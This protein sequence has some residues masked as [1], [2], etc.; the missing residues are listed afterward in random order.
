MKRLLALPLLALLACT[1]ASSTPEARAAR[2][3]AS[4]GSAAREVG[5]AIEASSAR[6]PASGTNQAARSGLPRLTG[7]AAAVQARAEARETE[8]AWELARREWATLDLAKLDDVARRFVR[9]RRADCAWRSLASTNEADDSGLVAAKKELTELQNAVE[10]PELRDELWARVEE[11]LA[12][13]HWLPRNRQD[14]GQAWP[15]YSNALD[16]WA[17]AKDVEA[18]RARYLAMV[19]RMAW[20]QDQLARGSWWA[21]QVPID[22]LANAMSIAKTKDDQARAKYLFAASVRWNGG[23]YERTRQAF[24]ALE[25][26]LELGKG[27]PWYDDAL[28][29]LAQWAESPGIP[30]VGEDGNWRYVPDYPKALALYRRYVEEFQK[31]QAARWDDAKQ[32]IERITRVEV[33]VAVPSAFLPGSEAGFTLAWRNAAKVDVALYA[34]DLANAVDLASEQDTSASAWLERVSTAGRERVRSFTHE[35]KD[36]GKHVPGST[37]LDL[38]AALAPGAY[39]LE[40]TAGGARS[41]ELVLVGRTQIVLKAGDERALAWVCDALTSEPVANA[42][43]VVWEHVYDGKRWSWARTAGTSA[44]DGTFT[45]ALSPLRAN[46]NRSELLVFAALGERES[47]A[48][49]GTAWERGRDD[50]W[51][52]YAVTDRPV[53][54]P[55]NTVQWKLTARAERDGRMTTPAGSRLGYELFDPRGTSVKKGELVL[56]AFGSAWAELALDATMALGEYRAQFTVKEP[57]SERGIGGA[58]L[59]RLEEYKLPEFEVTLAT[60]IVDGKAKLYRLGERVECDLVARTYFGAPVG[61]ADVEVVVYQR[62]FWRRWTDAREYPWCYATDDSWRWGRWNKGSQVTS[63]TAKTD[64]EGKARIAFDTPEG[65]GQDLEYTLEARVTDASRREIRSEQSIRVTQR[66]YD[67]RTKLAHQLARPGDRVTVEFEARDAN[68]GPVQAE[69]RVRL[70]RRRFVEVWLDPKGAEVRGAALDLARASDL[71]VPL[72][73]RAGWRLKKSGYEEELVAETVL[74]TNAEGKASWAVVVPTEGSYVARWGSRDDRR[75][76]IQSE[77]AF[78]VASEATRDTGWR[79]G[80]VE[81]VIDQDTFHLGDDA[82]VMIATSTSN[83]W[84]LFTLEGERLHSFQVVH[85]EGTAKL[86]RV[87]IR[88]EHLPNLWLGA[89]TV[90]AGELASDV[91]EVVVPPTPK[92][93]TVEVTPDAAQHEPGAPGKLSVLVKDARGEPVA[94]ELTLSVVDESVL[95]IQSEYA[96][97]PRPFFH[98]ERRRHD[99]QSS[100]STDSRSFRRFVKDAKGRLR[101]E[102]ETWAEGSDEDDTLSDRS[103]MKEE[104]AK[105]DSGRLGVRAGGAKSQLRAAGAPAAKP[106]GPSTGGPGGPVGRGEA[107]SLGFV[108][109]EAADAYGSGGAEPGGDAGGGAVQV[110]SDFRETALWKPD[111][112][113]GADGRGE[114]TFTYPESLTRWKATARAVTADSKA[115]IATTTTRTAKP[116]TARLQTP[117]FLVVG[118]EAVLSALVDNQTDAAVDAKAE[119]ALG[120]LALVADAPKSLSVP[121]HG[122]VRFDWKVRATDAGSAKLS[123]VARAGALSDG[124]TRALP[125]L[126][127]GID[128]QVARSVRVAEGEVAFT[129]DVPAARR[130]QDTRFEVQ[131]A[132]SLA[133]TMLDALPYLVDYPYGCTEQTMSR[134]LPAA[135]VAKTLKDRGLSAEDALQ[136]AFGGIEPET[137]AATHP[138]G[139]K[140]LELLTEITRLSLERLYDFQHADGG[141]GWWKQGDADAWM[142]AYVVWGLALARDAGLDV[143]ANRLARSAEWLKKAL[144]EAEDA[145]ELQAWELH[146]LAAWSKDARESELVDRAIQNLWAKK[147]GLNAYGRALYALACQGFG[148]TDR[149]KTMLDL[150]VNG[151]RIDETPDVARIDRGASQHH[152]STMKTAHWGADAVSWRWTDSRVESTACALRALMA[153]DPKHELVEP[154]MAWLTQNRR[155]AQWSNTRDTALAVLAL[156]AYL[157]TSGELARDLEYEVFVNGKSAGRAKL[158][159][160]DL[161]T[162]PGRY[163]VGAELVKDGANEVR[164]KLLS[165][166][167]PLYVSARARFFSL[168]EPIPS[169]GSQLFAARQYHALASRPTLLKGPAYDRVALL[170]QGTVRSGDRVEVVL[171]LEA[172]NDLEYLLIEDLKPAGFEAVETKSGE[173]MSARELKASEVAYRFGNGAPSVAPDPDDG[174]LYTGRQRGVH[175]ELRDRKVAFFVDRLPQGVWELRYVLR[176]EAPGRFHALPVLGEAMYVPEI[177]CNGAELRVTVTE[178]PDDGG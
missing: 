151:V 16:W 176:A 128:A 166:T 41:R 169:R 148:R 28:W 107:L 87:P 29:D 161:L 104:L 108:S 147:D 95:A 110:R 129:L 57:G 122:T 81:L 112:V 74:T 158:A 67:V 137:A 102:R 10:R 52:L 6:A 64:A 4:E 127:H 160:K 97:D 24:G 174:A 173:W 30:D 167:G 98:G 13:F 157:E 62:P 88:E 12:D 178:R 172:K 90:E 142:T 146:A 145:P 175:Q 82:P 58:T 26:A 164:V 103:E 3:A 7:D 114:A 15:H 83:R 63:V 80:P 14:W 45:A 123:L 56:N 89:T 118:D 101:D 91:K 71:A 55:E 78:W 33:S 5:A 85:V 50:G 51:K 31:G 135:I 149:A 132:P 121:A 154:V 163:T 120:G 40:A 96:G 119:L 73:H 76:P 159:A 140:S 168:E 69:G 47:V 141:Y 48:I 124:M 165:G 116:L 32:G 65:G 61:G 38:G 105:K 139:K 136:R 70:E 117:R 131:V 49:G 177:R 113:T 36:D 60:P 11:S 143:D 144:V 125:V 84:V 92:F 22:V 138:K 75:R 9:F 93:L 27:T 86:V 1:F 59:F 111:V 66:A 23:S 68:D 17:G 155:G 53:Y 115:G 133:V 72:E 134:F 20:P 162:A 130:K 34:L 35:T 171:T 156:N 150:L 126:A 94:A 109:N 106:G 43:L 54:R 153:I 37:E 46:G 21:R 79:S 2:P 42:K 99:V 39:L 25:S 8:G 77:G 44:A 18:A 100:A 19:W 152:A 170:D